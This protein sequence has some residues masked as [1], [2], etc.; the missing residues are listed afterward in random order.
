MPPKYDA[1]FIWRT[2]KDNRY[3]ILSNDTKDGTINMRVMAFACSQ[4]LHKFY[5]L[6][7][8]TSAKLTDFLKKPDVSLLVFSTAKE[9]GDY[10]QIAVK[11]KISIHREIDSEL[12]KAG[13]HQFAEKT[14][15]IGALLNSGNLGDYVFL[16]LEPKEI[17]LSVYIDILHNLPGTTIKF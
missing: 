2:L 16:I 6:T 1:D 15:M 9:V 7:L 14:G 12:V 3:C 11:G 5:L 8:K 4:D 13:L 10:S 17:T